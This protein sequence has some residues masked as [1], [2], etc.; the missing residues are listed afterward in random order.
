MKLLSRAERD[1]SVKKHDLAGLILFCGFIFAIAAGYLLPQSDFS[2]MEKRYL[3]EAPDFNL[4]AIF[5][6]DFSTGAEDYLS[7]HVLGR[8]LFVGI[9]AYTELLAGRQHLKDVWLEKGKLVE[10][11]VAANLQVITQNMNAIDRLAQG[12]G[13][14]IAVMVIPSAGWAAGVE[15]YSDEY[16]LNA[17]YA[18]A[19]DRIHPVAVE[20]IFRDHPELYYNTDHHWTSQGAYYG[21]KAFTEAVGRN[22][23]ASKD[24]EVTV[25]EGFRGSTYSRS[26]LWLT[27]PETI[28][29]W[30]GCEALTVTNLESENAHKGA[31]YLERLA[32]ADKY[33]VFLDGN[34]SLVRIQNPEQTGK[35]LV[36]RDSYGNCLGGFL[37]ES[38]GEVVLVDLRYYRQSVSELIRQ[39]NFDDILVC[40]SC[41]NFLTDTNLM[42][43]R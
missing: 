19:D 22:C 37:A 8:N 33:T 32:G 15:G 36:I 25:K 42:L 29:L 14:D 34:H 11:P 10:A 43:L 40:Y 41:A 24:F 4:G 28:E 38:Y 18:K 23:R 35:L 31:F 12:V 39:E 26:A 1:H 9:N 6:G 27:K 2:Q 16:T 30:Q 13:Q 7:D 3:A 17:I 21:Y 5:S 20:D